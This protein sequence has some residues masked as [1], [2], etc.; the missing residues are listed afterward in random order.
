MPFSTS[1]ETYWGPS[2]PLEII[3]LFGKSRSHLELGTGFTIIYSPRTT[4][5]DNTFEIEFNKYAFSSNLPFRI[6]YRYQKPDGGLIFR[7]GYTPMMELPNQRLEK[8]HFH[9]LYG[10]I[11][12]GKSF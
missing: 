1:R 9:L 3:A 2:V 8:P 7:I 6:G 4:I 10:G 5:N 11:S 12:L